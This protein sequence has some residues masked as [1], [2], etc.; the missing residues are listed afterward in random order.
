MTDSSDMK[1]RYSQKNFATTHWSMVLAAGETGDQSQTA[2]ESLCQSYWYPLYRYVRNRGFD[3]EKAADLTQGFFARLIEK[4][5]FESVRREKG[6][7]R[8][9]LLASIQ[10]F[11]ANECDKEK[12]IKRGGD[13]STFSIDAVDAEKRY[14]LEP[15]NI[16]TPELGFEKTW[17]MT[18]LEQV[19]QKLR[20]E[21]ERN[22]KLDAFNRFSG[23]LGGNHADLPSYQALATELGISESAVKVNIHRMRQQFRK[24]LRQEIANTVASESDVDDELNRMFQVLSQ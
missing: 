14:R 4:N 21:F 8:N 7:F 19:H 18:L 2:L 20:L 17:A 12:A 10:N 22:G 5:D 16:Q 13:V 23:Y 6:R 9:F 1:I 11:V 15:E 24:L 3:Q